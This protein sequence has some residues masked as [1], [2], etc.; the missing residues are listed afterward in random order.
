LAYYSRGNAYYYKGE[1]EN[2][3][4]DIQKARSLGYKVPSDFYKNL[5]EAYEKLKGIS[6][7]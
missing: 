3:W 5:R 4:V 6:P 7:N 2:A 1:Y